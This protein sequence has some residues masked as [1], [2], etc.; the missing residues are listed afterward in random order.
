[1]AI[2]NWNE[3]FAQVREQCLKALKERLIERANIIQSRYEEES[4]MLSKRQA[5]F[6][7]DREQLSKDEE[8]EHEQQVE[9]SQ[10]KIKV[11]VYAV[12]FGDIW[13]GLVLA[14]LVKKVKV[15]S[16]LCIRS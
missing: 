13:G 14:Y 4:V 16:L 15:M 6:L 2:T 7:R 12:Y 5:A 9:A 8:L 1:M 10:F 3:N 11:C